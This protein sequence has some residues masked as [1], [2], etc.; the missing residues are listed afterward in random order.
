MI[1]SALAP[2]ILPPRSQQDP[3]ATSNYWPQSNASFTPSLCNDSDLTQTRRRPRVQTKPH[4]DTYHTS[5]RKH[6]TR[7]YTPTHTHARML[8]YARTHAH[9]ST[10][11][12]DTRTYACTHTGAHE[13]HTPNNHTY[14]HTYTHTHTRR[15][16]R[17]HTDTY[18]R[19]SAP[20]LAEREFPVSIWEWGNSGV[21]FQRS[22]FWIK[23]Q[24][25]GS[26]AIILCC[27]N[28]VVVREHRTP[29]Q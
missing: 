7:T 26:I 19:C 6:S 16:I 22:G 20:K 12:P 9:I 17:T 3:R 4:A 25:Y 14:I 21:G 13:R 27:R 1:R 18:H 5:R 28:L 8:I 10:H 24:H 15:Y 23:V 11:A 29:C 2:G